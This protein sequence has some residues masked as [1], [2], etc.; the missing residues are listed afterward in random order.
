MSRRLEELS[1][2]ALVSGG[3]RAQKAAEEAGF[4]EELRQK[5]E[6][7]IAGADFKNTYARELSQANLP[8]YAGKGTRDLAGAQHWTGEE[9]VEDAS[10]RMLNDSMVKPMRTKPRVPGVP[11][12][13]KVDTGRPAPGA[14]AS[15]GVRLANARDQTSVYSALRD[16]SM[17]DEEREKF[18]REMQERFQSHGRT[19]AWSVR[20]LES[21]ANERIED[22]IARGQFRNIPRGQKIE[23]D[24]NMGNPFLDTTEYFMNKIIQKQEIVPPWIE[25]QQELVGNAS[26]FRSR[27]RNDWRRHAARMIASKGGTLDAQIR[28]AQAYAAAEKIFNP[29]APKQET[30]NAV[31]DEGHLSQITLSGEL[32]A[33]PVPDPDEPEEV[34]VT[35]TSDVGAAPTDAQAIEVTTITALETTT[36]STPGPTPAAIPA[37]DH[38]FRD[39]DW[40]AAE[41]SYLTLAV[42]ELNNLTRSYNLMAPDLAKK[43]YFSLERELRAAFAD[44]APQVAE[45]IQNRATRAPARTLGGKGNVRKGGV[46]ERLSGP[47]VKVYDEVRPQYGFKEFWRD[48]FRKG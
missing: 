4:S 48:L 43:P 7:R 45:E 28:R 14:A 12:P 21:L 22:A 47:E 42:K 5:L 41:H 16:S 6:E 2:D 9:S 17:T 37:A 15:K 20:A 23:R 13:K 19:A 39:A 46:M 18:R 40:E 10:L 25:K 3:R 26:R 31:N 1:E 27:L 29:K 11:T 38:P 44:V 35:A 32:K 34:T 8:S 24:Y 36:N 33:S 30:L